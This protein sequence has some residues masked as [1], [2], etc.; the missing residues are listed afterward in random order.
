MADLPVI[1]QDKDKVYYADTCEPLKAA[2]QRGE[3]Y[4][5]AWSRGSYPG[6]RLPPTT[7]PEVRSIG[8]WD[9]P[10]PQSWGLDLHCNEGI[11]F[12]YLARGKT[13]F[14]VD[15]KSWLL[16]KGDLT[17]TR[18]WQFHRVGNPQVGASRLYWLILDVNVRRPNQRW[19][20]PDWLVCSRSDLKQL[21][22]LLSHNEQP[23]WPANEEIARCFTRLAELLESHELENSET[24]LKLYINELV[25]TV[26]EMLQQKQIPLDSRLPTSQRAVEMF[27]AALPEHAASDWDL[28]AMAGQCGLS[29][30]QFSSYCKQL[31][32]MTP[33]EYLIHCRLDLAA[34]LL[35]EYA[36][37]SITQVAFASGFNSS[38]YFATTFQSHRG[39]SP[40]DFRN[41]RLKKEAV[42]LVLA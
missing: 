7:L 40:S 12:T 14:E 1:F 15:G 31:T 10:R 8:I 3:V 9:A 29:R 28:G 24:K 39:C 11:E 16:K 18:P 4:L 38:Q 41:Q 32:N 27:L 25:I 23:V 19:R 21:T 37:M 34:R 42:D 26:L 17:I 13:G 33:V 2:A 22:R 20:W 36:G 30:S 35:V 6:L 5:H